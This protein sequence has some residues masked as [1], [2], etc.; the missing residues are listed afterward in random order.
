MHLL[1]EASASPPPTD[2]REGWC[3]VPA[4]LVDAK[5]SLFRAVDRAPGGA[6][7]YSEA[8]LVSRRLGILR[9]VASTDHEYAFGVPCFT[10]K[11]KAVAVD[12]AFLPHDGRWNVNRL[13]ELRTQVFGILD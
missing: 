8:S 2:Q 12:L 11:Q 3:F 7:T 5:G 4:K 9:H 6:V 10:E 1:A 13:I